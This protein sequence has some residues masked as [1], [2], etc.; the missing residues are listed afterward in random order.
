MPGAWHG[1]DPIVCWQAAL[2]SPIFQCTLN[3]GACVI[4]RCT[5][6][7]IGLSFIT[8]KEG[9]GKCTLRHADTSLVALRGSAVHFKE[10]T[11]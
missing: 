7:D 10:A 1:T 11:S 5:A 9:A 8:L 2:L 3:R 4:V 6:V